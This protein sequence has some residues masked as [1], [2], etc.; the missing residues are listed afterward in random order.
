MKPKDSLLEQVDL[1]LAILDEWL[2]KKQIPW[3]TNTDGT[4]IRDE[5]GEMIPDFAP[6]NL[7]QFC[8]WTQ[9]KN[10]TAS[11]EALSS[12]RRISRMSLHQAYHAELRKRVND[13]L[14]VIKTCLTLQIERSNKVSIIEDQAAQ[15]QLLQNIVDA[16]ARESRLARHKVTEITQKYR[17]RHDEQ[18]RIIQQLKADIVA[19]EE[20]IASLTATLSKVTSLR[21]AKQTGTPRS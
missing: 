15:I 17:Q 3:K 10:C 2:A 8:D 9:E 12:L 20:K 13:K 4:P 16:Q 1:R 7:L 21:V 6:V 18:R 11:G 14:K 5:N 19:H